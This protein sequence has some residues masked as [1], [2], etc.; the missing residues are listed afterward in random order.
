MQR[1]ADEAPVAF[2]FD[3]F[4]LAQEDGKWQL[5]PPAAEISADD[6]NRWVDAWRLATALGVQPASN[7]KPLATARIKLKSGTEITVA[8]LQRE[9]Q[10][11]L[12][13]SDQSY[14]YQF[15]ADAAKRLLARPAPIPVEK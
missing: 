3:D 4:K 9:P 5:M 7:K 8:V 15:T 13:R 6:I 14:E 12:A 10:L 1:S 2:G 11:V